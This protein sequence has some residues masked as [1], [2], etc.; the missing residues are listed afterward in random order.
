MD[1][2]TTEESATA[3]VAE[4]VDMFSVQA[5][6]KG[7][8]LVL[9]PHPSR[10]LLESDMAVRVITD[11]RQ[12]TGDSRQQTVDSRQQTIDSRQQTVESIQ[13]TVDGRRCIKL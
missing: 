5:R 6:A 8:G 13:L 12:Q 3:F 9:A 11:S 1:L 2:H 10:P 4:C 7:V